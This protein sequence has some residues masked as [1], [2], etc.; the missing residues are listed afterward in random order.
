LPRLK[1]FESARFDVPPGDDAAVLNGRSPLVLSI[2][3]LTEDTHFRMSWSQRVERIG[4]FS[5]ARGLGW[6]LLGSAL[7]D[8]AAMGHSERRWAMIYL[9]GRG[10]LS[11]NFLNDLYAGLREKA[12]RYRCALAGGDT[13][14]AHHTTLVAAVGA[15]QPRARPLRRDAAKAGDVILVAGFIGDASV[16]LDVLDG[17]VRVGGRMKKR[18]AAYFVRRFFEHTPEFEVA[19]KLARLKHIACAMDV[20]DS[21]HETV[22]SVCEMSGVSAILHVE[23]IPV[24]A[25][26]R[27]WA[28]FGPALLSAGEN[29]ALLF[30]CPA[31][32]ARAAAAA[33]GAS[34]VGVITSAR[35]PPQYFLDGKPVQPSPLFGHFA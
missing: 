4:G 16:G 28:T 13:V 8:L 17:S 33:T 5:L 26:Y 30:T 27:R 22:S 21:L 19:E 10:S 1:R 9:G 15:D 23:K 2:D 34:I 6:K 29:Y 25:F 12:R 3:G 14:R 11:L 35:R 32:R 20:S 24:S 18:S 31:T 7:S